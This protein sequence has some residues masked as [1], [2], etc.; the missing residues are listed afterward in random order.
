MGSAAPPPCRCLQHR[1]RKGHDRQQQGRAGIKRHR[2]ERQNH[3]CD[4][5]PDTGAEV[6]DNRTPPPK[7][8]GAVEKLAP[9]ETKTIEVVFEYPA[10]IA[11]MKNKV[12]V[13]QFCAKW[14]SEW[15]RKAAYAPGSYDW[16]ESFEV[17]SEIR[18]ID[19]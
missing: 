7:L 13:L 4:Q 16:N 6:V 11:T 17:C 19:E 8:D 5:R 10:G 2:R 15:L 18:I 9:A 3:T 12:A 14:Q 1:Q